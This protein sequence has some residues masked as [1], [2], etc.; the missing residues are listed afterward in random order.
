MRHQGKA[1]LIDHTVLFS[2][3][4]GSVASWQKK[5]K[6]KCA[7]TCN[8]M[9]LSDISSIV[10]DSATLLRIERESSVKFPIR[11]L[12]NR[13]LIFSHRTLNSA[14]HCVSLVVTVKRQESNR[15]E[16]STEPQDMRFCVFIH[17]I[18]FY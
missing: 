9:S 16:V 14:T 11:L 7:V 17:S 3:E 12:L 1:C 13:L 4:S 10:V 15:K 6:S 2:T 8:G 18:N 5:L